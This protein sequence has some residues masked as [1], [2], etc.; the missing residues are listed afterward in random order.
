MRL[1]SKT[2]SNASQ[3]FYYGYL[4]SEFKFFSDLYIYFCIHSRRLLYIM[5][6]INT[7]YRK[8]NTYNNTIIFNYNKKFICTINM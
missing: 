1:S 6:T 4:L 7:D 5:N 8:K 2:L 3:T